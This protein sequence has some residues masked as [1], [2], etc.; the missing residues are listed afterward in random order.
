MGH[1]H[2]NPEGLAKIDTKELVR[3]LAKRKCVGHIYIDPD[4]QCVIAQANKEGGLVITHNLIGQ[5]TRIL[6]VI[7]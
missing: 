1:G 5:P 6:V 7:D 2:E 4:R 3:E